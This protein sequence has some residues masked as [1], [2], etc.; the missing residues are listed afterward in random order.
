MAPPPIERL[1]VNYTYKDI[2]INKQPVNVVRSVELVGKSQRVLP[3][4]DRVESQIRN[5]YVD[6]ILYTLTNVKRPADESIVKHYYDIDSLK[7]AIVKC[8]KVKV[9][10]MA[11]H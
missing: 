1:T 10:L 7:D 8:D 5:R 9:L 2:E 6:T 3:S 11:T 4:I